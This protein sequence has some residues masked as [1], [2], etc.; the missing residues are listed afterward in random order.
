MQERVSDSVVVLERAPPRIEHR[1]LLQ[2]P[3]SESDIHTRPFTH[4]HTTSWHSVSGSCASSS[5]VNRPFTTSLAVH[6]VEGKVSYQS[7]A[8]LEKSREGSPFSI[9]FL[10]VASDNFSFTILAEAS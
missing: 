8:T 4:T 7:P 2:V 6:G 3:T 1:K 5:S 9:S 10:K